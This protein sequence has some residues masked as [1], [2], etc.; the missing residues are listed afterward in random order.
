MEPQRLVNQ[1]L[2]VFY[3]FPLVKNDQQGI[4]AGGLPIFFLYWKAPSFSITLLRS[5]V[6]EKLDI[7]M[8][9]AFQIF[10]PLRSNDL[11]D[12]F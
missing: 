1:Q 12:V 4:I 2:V 8:K 9:L 11:K 6:M 7:W 10:Q 3:V 5:S